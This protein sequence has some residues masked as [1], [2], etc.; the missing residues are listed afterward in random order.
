MELSEVQEIAKRIEAGGGA[1][2]EEVLS[3]VLDLAEYAEQLINCNSCNQVNWT[4]VRT[5]N[6]LKHLLKPMNR[7]WIVGS[8]EGGKFI[9]DRVFDD[10]ATAKRIAE[11]SVLY[12]GSGWVVYEAPVDDFG[13]DWKKVHEV[14]REPV[15]KKPPLYAVGYT[16][17]RCAGCSVEN[18]KRC[19]YSW[20]W[21]KSKQE[22][23]DAC[24]KRSKGA[25]PWAVWESPDGSCDLA[26][27]VEVYRWQEPGKKS[28]PPKPVV[29]GTFG[30]LPAPHYCVRTGTLCGSAKW[31]AEPG[32][33]C[34]RCEAHRRKSRSTKDAATA[35]TKEDRLVKRVLKLL[36]EELAKEGK[37]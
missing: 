3:V 10:L 28:E 13:T 8:L 17:T 18:P 30:C 29:T 32:C 35:E 4:V 22:A 16:D 2:R 21:L 15:K 14:K 25:G 37:A 31:D 7:V 20:K 27:A 11:D 9:P 26:T 12:P 24:Q 1:T 23:I 5:F 6:R 36:R 19:T 34:V 33:D